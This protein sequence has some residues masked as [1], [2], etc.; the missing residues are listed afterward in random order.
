MV[1]IT[2]S[3]PHGSGKSTYAKEI[4]KAL[5]LK[6]VSS[7]Q[8]FRRLAKDSGCDLETFSKKCEKDKNIDRKIDQ[9]TIDE[10]KKG[11]AILEGQ[12]AAWMAKDFSDFNIYVSAS[13][14]IR[15]RRIAERDGL[16][17]E[18]ARRE[19]HSRTKSEIMR[20]KRYYDIDLTNM[21]IYDLILYTDRLSKEQCIDLLI[22]ICKHVQSFQ[23]S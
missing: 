11:N 23:Q 9:I 14:E 22:A 4:A 8:I 13:E 10:A 5:Q 16:D 1:V 20:F 15:V 19:T 17:L 7:G 12:L 18:S 3:G 21:T 6:Y 2:I